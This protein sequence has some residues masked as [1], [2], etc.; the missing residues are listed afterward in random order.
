[1]KAAA[2]HIRTCIRRG[3]NTMRIDC[4]HCGLRFQRRIHHQGVRSRRLVRAADAGTRCIRRLR[5]R[6]QETSGAARREHWHHAGGC[7]AWLVVERNTLT[8]EIYSVTD[9]S[10]A[11]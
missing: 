5:L 11:R 10:E 8:H 6:R 3:Q 7:R 1:M 2:D 9:V 4:P